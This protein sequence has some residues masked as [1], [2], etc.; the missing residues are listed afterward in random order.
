[1]DLMVWLDVIKDPKGT[2]S[3][4]APNATAQNGLIHLILGSIISII[5]ILLFFNLDY[6]LKDSAGSISLMGVVLSSIMFTFLFGM[7]YAI[8]V[9]PNILL[10]FLFSMILGGNGSVEKHFYLLSITYAPFLIL[11]SFTVLIDILLNKNAANL[12]PVTHAAYIIGLICYQIY[13]IAEAHKLSL[14]M[15]FATVFLTLVASI[16]LLIGF[17][18]LMRSVM[19]FY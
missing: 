1:M 15:A 19:P 8:V 10:L 11:F 4:E 14:P 9:F 7:I 2:L 18:V 13:A 12:N 17:F 3:K 6:L 5:L 16:V